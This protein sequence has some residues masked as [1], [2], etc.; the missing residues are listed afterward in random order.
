[1]VD[2]LTPSSRAIEETVWSGWA[3]R[4]SCTPPANTPS[5]NW[6]SCSRSPGPPCTESSNATA[7]AAGLLRPLDAPAPS[8][9]AQEGLAQH[10]GVADTDL[11]AMS[12]VPT[13][14]SDGDVGVAASGTCVGSQRCGVTSSLRWRALADPTAWLL[15]AVCSAPGL[16]A[17]FAARWAGARPA[18][19][20]LVDS[21]CSDAD[22]AS[23]V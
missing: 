12:G 20:N 8:R 5:P 7:F 2:R 1:M 14:F 3:S 19:M 11:Q 21:A 22:A 10:Q 17:L 18:S 23:C 9:G 6:P 4:C 15:S 16:G 13:A